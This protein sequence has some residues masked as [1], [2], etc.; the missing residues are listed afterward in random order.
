VTGKFSRPLNG[1]SAGEL[2][3]RI[4]A[5]HFNINAGIGERD[6]QRRKLAERK[7]LNSFHSAERKDDQQTK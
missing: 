7:K 2:L 4:Q 6:E 3:R 5:D 1:I